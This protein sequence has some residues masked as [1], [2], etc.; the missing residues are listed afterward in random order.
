MRYIVKILN[1]QKV[2]YDTEKDEIFNFTISKL[3]FI[4]NLLNAH[5]DLIE[6]SIDIEFEEINDNT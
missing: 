4:C 1:N 3:N 6:N 2:I 5:S